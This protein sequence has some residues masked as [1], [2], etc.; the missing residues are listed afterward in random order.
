MKKAAFTK[1][2]ESYYDPK[3]Q[4]SGKMGLQLCSRRRYQNCFLNTIY[5]SRLFI[6]HNSFQADSLTEDKIWTEIISLMRKHYIFQDSD[7][8]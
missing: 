7:D 6:W 5:V 3:S 1:M 2:S 8:I 4:K